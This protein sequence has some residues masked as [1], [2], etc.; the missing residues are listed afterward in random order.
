VELSDEHRDGRDE[1]GCRRRQGDLFWLL[2]RG[3]QNAYDA[4]DDDRNWTA[5]PGRCKPKGRRDRDGECGANSGQGRRHGV[6]PKPAGGARPCHALPS[7][8]SG[9]SFG[10]P[11]MG[12]GDGLSIGHA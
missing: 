4:R 11:H 3:E 5:R 1:N 6:R 2:Q 12:T 10:K 8:Q 7:I 9:P